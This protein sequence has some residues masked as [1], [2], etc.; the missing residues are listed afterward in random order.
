MAEV[1]GPRA[2]VP[3]LLSHGLFDYPMNPVGRKVLNL[4]QYTIQGK[5]HKAGICVSFNL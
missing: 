1:A 3:D 5:E 2:N 4:L